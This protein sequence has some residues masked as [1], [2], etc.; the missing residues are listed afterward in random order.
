M[1]GRLTAGQGGG[2]DGDEMRAGVWECE[3]VW[4]REF[5]DKMRAG[6]WMRA[7]V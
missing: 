6:V 7:G 5:Q 4:E 1:T 2:G 3:V